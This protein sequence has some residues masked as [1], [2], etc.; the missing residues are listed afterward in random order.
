MNKNLLPAPPP[1]LKATPIYK[2][3]TT[4]KVFKYIFLKSTISHFTHNC[5]NSLFKK[6][7]KNVYLERPRPPLYPLEAQGAPLRPRSA[8]TTGA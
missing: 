8:G 1:S 6:M 5:M 7:N 2:N 4:K 3:K